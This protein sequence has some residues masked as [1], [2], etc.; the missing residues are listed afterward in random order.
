MLAYIADCAYCGHLFFSGFLSHDIDTEFLKLRLAN[1]PVMFKPRRLNTPKQ[2]FRAPEIDFE[3]LPSKSHGYKDVGSGSRTI[4]KTFKNRRTGFSDRASDVC[5]AQKENPLLDRVQMLSP[6][7]LGLAQS[8]GIP[9]MDLVR[10]ADMARANKHHSAVIMDLS[11][12]RDLLVM[13]TLRSCNYMAP[14]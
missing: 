6:S 5:L 8:V 2:N 1:A 14:A 9:S 11:S 13:L 12:R 3:Y 10:I 7:T 4:V